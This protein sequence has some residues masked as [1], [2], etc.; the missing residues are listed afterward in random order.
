[1][2]SDQANKLV[3]IHFNKNI[4]SLYSKTQRKSISMLNKYL[5]SEAQRQLLTS[6]FSDEYGGKI[7][8]V[9]L[10]KWLRKEEVKEHLNEDIIDKFR[11]TTAKNEQISDQSKKGKATKLFEDD[12]EDDDFLSDIDEGEEVFSEDE[13]DMPLRRCYAIGAT[14]DRKD[15]S[16]PILMDE[17]GDD[18]T[19]DTS[20]PRLILNESYNMPRDRSLAQLYKHYGT[21]KEACMNEK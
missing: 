8:G 7:C 20:L 12:L 16:P 14:L 2:H 17:I 21:S 15:T 10:R 5:Q 3:Y 9:D 11:K 6:K 18:G 13:F 19:L 4:S 1:M